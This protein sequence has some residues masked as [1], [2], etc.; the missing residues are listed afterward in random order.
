MVGKPAF[1]PAPA[2]LNLM[3]HIVGRREDGYHLLQT[4]FQFLDYSDEL[5]FTL[6][7]DGKIRRVTRDESVPEEQ[8]LVVRAAR[9]LAQQ[10]AGGVPGVDIE[11]RKKIPMGAGLGGGSSDA[12]TVH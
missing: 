9:L 7:N 10:V 3:L 1:F 4:V 2:K 11:I 12:A 6:R 5:G 8:D